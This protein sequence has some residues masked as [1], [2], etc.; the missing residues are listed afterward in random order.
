MFWFSNFRVTFALK[1]VFPFLFH[2]WLFPFLFLVTTINDR[3]SVCTGHGQLNFKDG[4]CDCDHLYSGII[5][6]YKGN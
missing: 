1:P 3:K 4:K 2:F 6:Q 5:C